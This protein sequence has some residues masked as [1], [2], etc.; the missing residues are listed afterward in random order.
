MSLKIDI[1]TEIIELT[2]KQKIFCEEYCVDYNASRSA[3]K[4]GYS[5]K[6][7]GKIGFENLQKLEIQKYI[8]YCKQNISEL[9]G[10][11]ALRNLKELASIS[12]S[13]IGDLKN[14]WISFKDFDELTEDQKKAIKAC[15][16]TTIRNELGETITGYKIVLHDKLKAIE[17]INKQLGY[18]ATDKLDL[19]SK[20]E[21]IEGNTFLV[22]TKDLGEKISN[23]ID[24]L[25]ED[26][27]E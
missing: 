12:Y 2:E 15:E 13:N 23:F 3:L 14:G 1:G 27:E 18:N 21:Q 17:T 9:A 25:K 8:A 16:I 20:G 24:E 11:S 22:S 4:A 10:V 19:T 6:T 26:D 5:E 7:Y